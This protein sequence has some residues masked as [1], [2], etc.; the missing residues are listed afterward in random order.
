[1][2]FDQN[3]PV[4]LLEFIH[5][6][7]ERNIP[8]DVVV[9][10]FAKAYDKGQHNRLLYKLKWYGINPKT[11]KWISSFLSNRSQS[12]VVEGAKSAAVQYYQACLKARS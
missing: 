2:A 8:V 12:V 10:D 11:L 9:M 6:S 4:K 1:M 3:Y 5:V 7:R